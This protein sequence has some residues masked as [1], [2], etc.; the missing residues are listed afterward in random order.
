MK[1]P[2]L[3]LFPRIWRLT[4]ANCRSAV[5]VS[6]RQG[7]LSLVYCGGAGRL[8]GPSKAARATYP[9]YQVPLAGPHKKPPKRT[10]PKSHRVLKIFDV[11]IRFFLFFLL[12]FPSFFPPSPDKSLSK[13][14]N[15]EDIAFGP[16]SHT[17]ELRE[18]VPGHA[19]IRIIFR[20]VGS[21][22]RAAIEAQRLSF[23]ACPL[24][25]PFPTLLAAKS[26][27]SPR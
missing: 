16:S 1:N 13:P 24:S 18:K 9:S 27:I 19:R 17:I 11:P 4:L 21:R 25:D 15:G 26:A 6:R 2:K 5:T 20:V 12:S 8:E 10:H 23:A 7:C 22:K 14:T 3:C